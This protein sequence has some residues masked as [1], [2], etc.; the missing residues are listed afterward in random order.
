MNT[1]LDDSCIRALTDDGS[2]RVMVARTTQT[3]RQIAEAQ[4]ARDGTAQNLG[5]L[6]TATVLFRETMS[7]GLRVQGILRCADR[8]GTLVADSAPEGRTRGLVQGG[9]DGP[10]LA[11]EGAMLQMMRTLHNGSIN[12]GLVRVPPGGGMTEAMMAYMRESEQVDTML[13]VATS[14]G[15][16]GTVLEAGGYMIQ[17]LP[18]V[19]RA[20]LAIMAARLEDFRSIEHLLAPDFSA[21]VLLS[22]LLYGMSFTRLEE[23]KVTFSCW[24]STERLL[25]AI[26]TLK[27]HEIR[28]MVEDGSPVQS[29]C[30]YCG[31]EYAIQTSQLAGLLQQN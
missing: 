24:C 21:E 23:T 19:G 25:A 22:E 18:E 26:A 13:A 11:S 4:G 27:P 12:Q 2:F 10:I 31:K 1:P 5:D 8:R 17:L 7:P 20:P 30:D 6:L 16:D 9:K 14:I 28:A 15:H 29:S 3:V